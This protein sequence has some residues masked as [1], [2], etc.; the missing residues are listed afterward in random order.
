MQALDGNAIGGLLLG[1]QRRADRRDGHVCALRRGRAGGRA[2]GPLEAP[3]TVVRCRSCEAVVMVVV[4]KD[5]DRLRRCA[6][7]ANSN[8]REARSRR[9]HDAGTQGRGDPRRRPRRPR[10]RRGRRA[11]PR[12]PISSSSTSSAVSGAGQP[13]LTRQA[14]LLP[15]A[16][17]DR[18][19]DAPRR[20]LRH[21][22]EQPRA[23]LRSRGPARHVRALRSAGSCGWVRGRASRRRGDLPSSR[24]TASVSPC[25]VAA[26]IRRSSRPDPDSP[27][28]A[29]GLDWVAAA[30]NGLDADAVLVSPHWGPNMTPS[31]RPHVPP[32]GGRHALC[33]RDARRRPSAHVFHGAEPGVLYDLGDFLDDYAVNSRLR[34]D[35]GLLFSSRS[36][37]ASGA[38]R[39]FRSLDLPHAARRR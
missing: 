23:R 35:L 32:R 27:G 15:G 38:A 9:G 24:S 7:S 21:A 18:G 30:I 3:G 28:I 16:A 36:T 33:G 12:P 25:W 5:Q 31:P 4:E 10:R 11:S 39:Q 37:R 29:Y 13:W 17:G 8:V 22:R 20:R 2:R 6:G 14:V 19:P 26:T 34:N 1:V